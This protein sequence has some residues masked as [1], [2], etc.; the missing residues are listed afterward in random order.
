MIWIWNAYDDD[1]CVWAVPDCNHE[2][3][4]FLGYRYGCDYGY[5]YGSDSVSVGRG[6]GYDCDSCCVV[7]S[8]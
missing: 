3:Q 7:V 5:G 2:R 6:Y 4:P 1:L 8:P